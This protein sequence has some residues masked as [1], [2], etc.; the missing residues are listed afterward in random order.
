MRDQRR[1]E[2]RFPD[3]ATLHPGYRS[4][5]QAAGNQHL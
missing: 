2:L 4:I 5:A 1:D 3:F